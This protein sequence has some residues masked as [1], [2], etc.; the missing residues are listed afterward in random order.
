[1]I[2]VRPFSSLGHFKNEWLNARHHFSFSDYRDPERHH[3]GLVRVWNDDTIEPHTGFAPHPHKDMEIITYVRTG[4]ITHRDSLGNEGR[5]EAGDV[6]VMSAGSGIQHEEQNEEDIATQLFQ[7]WVLPKEKGGE[8]FWASAK[9]PK[10]DRAGELV[11]LATG[12]PRFSDAL[13]IRQDATI[14]G[15]TLRAGQSVTHK[16][17]EDRRIY[18]VTTNGSIEVN[19]TQLNPRDGAAIEDEDQIVI[20]AKEDAEIVLARYATAQQLVAG[21]RQAYSPSNSHN[22]MTDLPCASRRLR[23]PQVG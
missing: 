19:G 12:E 6:Q 4:A 20:A 23:P 1:M 13:P 7:I 5:T 15:A 2:E 16:V 10:A 14:F 18:L 3:W 11:A 17:R 21:G 9:F 8:P 22:V